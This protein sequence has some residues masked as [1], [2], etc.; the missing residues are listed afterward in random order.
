VTTT[1]ARWITPPICQGQIV[2]VAYIQVG[3]TLLRKTHDRSDRS[4]VYDRVVLKGSEVDD[5]DP[6]NREPSPRGSWARIS[7]AQVE[8]LIDEGP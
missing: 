3:S 7:E 5:V 2:E 4:T 8:R 1:A 6:I